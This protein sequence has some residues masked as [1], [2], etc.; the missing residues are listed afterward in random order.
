MRTVDPYAREPE[1][2]SL[3]QQYVRVS[4]ETLGRDICADPD[5][6]GL[7]REALGGLMKKIFAMAQ[8]VEIF[9]QCPA[10]HSFLE[11]MVFAV[12]F[13]LC[14]GGAETAVPLAIR[15]LS[16]RGS[17]WYLDEVINSNQQSR[18]FACQM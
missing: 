2:E 6:R 4:D 1:P 7:A 5:T 15:A 11:R 13:T 14:D 8:I 12:G 18:E 9:A 3:R 10:L 16:V 17:W